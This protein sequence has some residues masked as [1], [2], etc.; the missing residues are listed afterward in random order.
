M[1]INGEGYNSPK[2]NAENPEQVASWITIQ[3]IKVNVQP[4]MK[5]LIVHCYN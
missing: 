3:K 4:K 1:L 5:L 2:S